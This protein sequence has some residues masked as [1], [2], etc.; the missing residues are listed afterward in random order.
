LLDSHGFP[1]GYCALISELSHSPQMLFGAPLFC[2]CEI[3]G[4]IASFIIMFDYSANQ[5][6][7]DQVIFIINLLLFFDQTILKLSS[8][9]VP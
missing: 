5:P 7:E 1:K 3:R 6:C 4:L 8:G 9:F 2:F